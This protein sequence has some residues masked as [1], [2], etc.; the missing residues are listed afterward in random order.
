M[1]FDQCL[2][3]I[4]STFKGISCVTAAYSFLFKYLIPCGLM[5]QNSYLV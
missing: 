2:S 4:R 5:D 1:P 3:I